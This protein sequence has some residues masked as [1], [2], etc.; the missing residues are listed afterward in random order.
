MLIITFMY[1]AAYA[2]NGISGRIEDAN[3][4][5]KDPVLP[6]QMRHAAEKS[7]GCF[8]YSGISSNVTK[9]Q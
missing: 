1:N 2:G 4:K 5:Q 7:A 3:P 9:F 8:K 6:K